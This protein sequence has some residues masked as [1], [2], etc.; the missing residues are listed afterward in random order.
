MSVRQFRYDPNQARVPAGAPGGGRWG[1]GTTGSPDYGQGQ[2]G[3]VG[4]GGSSMS[5][6]LGQSVPVP[7]RA[8]LEA[9][10]DPIPETPEVESTFLPHIGPDGK[11]S[12]A[13][14]KV[15]D[16]LI[17][18]ALTDPTTG[19]PYPKSETK[20]ALI[21]G[22]GAASGKSSAIK[23]GHV[24]APDGAVTVNP[25]EFK[26]KLPESAGPA[27]DGK[28]GNGL[29]DEVGPAWA[30]ITHE[31][32]SHL[33]KRLT[34]AAIERETN[35]L[36]DKTSSDG[37][38]AVKEIKRLQSEGYDVEVAYVTTEVDTAVSNAAS[39][40]E[41][42]GRVV[43]DSVL[44][45]GH[46][47]ANAAFL[48]VVTQTTAAAKL[49]TT[50]P[51]NTDGSHR[52]PVLTAVADGQGGLVVHDRS[53]WEQYVGRVPSIPASLPITYLEDDALAA[54]AGVAQGDTLTSMSK[55]IGDD[56]MKVLYGA[57]IAGKQP[58][59]KMTAH[60]KAT[61][62]KL[63]TEVADIKAKGVAPD[64]PINDVF[65]DTGIVAVT[66]PRTFKSVD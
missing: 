63:V 51:A 56:R 33:G 28:Q 7:S 18:T 15:H 5:A 47:G 58:D 59:S 52:A 24:D 66:R 32:S 64:F 27:K 14:Q 20:K 22:G 36:I 40:G 12:A 45:A 49:V 54:T 30:S 44:R 26:V 8:E 3:S 34:T 16:D 19:E 21:M 62:D 2:S 48:D 37:P 25:D 13:R 43:P 42:I 57:A 6:S 65:A 4:D 29:A 38:K 53:A 35:I 41:K 17:E 31:E 23:A 50:L 9:G 61:F 60:E 11:L 55:A 1:G 39:R 10:F 46:E